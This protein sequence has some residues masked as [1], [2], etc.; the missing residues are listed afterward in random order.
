M[1][2]ELSIAAVTATLRGLIESAL[3]GGTL[4]TTLPPS[5]AAV[6]LPRPRTH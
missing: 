3:S 6:P 4:V 1:S 2:D 5:K